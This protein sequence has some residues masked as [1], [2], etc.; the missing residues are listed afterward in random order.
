M[1][2]QINTD[3]Q[4]T[5]K[6]GQNPV[7]QPVQ[8]PDKLKVNYW[9]ISTITLFVTLLFGGTYTY[10]L[11]KQI[12]KTN[13][14]DSAQIITPTSSPTTTPIVSNEACK[15]ISNLT[16][17][18]YCDGKSGHMSSYL[19]TPIGQQINHVSRYT[20]SPN[21]KWIFIVRWSDAF[22]VEGGRGAPD[23]YALTM[24]DV[25]NSKEY[26]LFSQIYFPTYRDPESWSLDGKGIVFTAGGAAIPDILGNP[27]MFAVVYC[28]ISCRVLAKNAGPAGIGGDPAFFEGNEVLYTGMNDEKIK[29]PFK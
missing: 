28:T 15:N 22:V 1:E 7:I 3:N 12:Q 2:N 29:I 18:Q 17:Y 16:G 6:I 21:K 11:S 26:E 25:K 9:M 10:N 5:Q 13:D 19:T 23:E 4:N 14:F 20:V 27:N 24:V 8:I